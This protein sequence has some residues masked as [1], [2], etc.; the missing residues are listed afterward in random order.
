MNSAYQARIMERFMSPN[1]IRQFNQ[2]YKDN[3]RHP[4]RSSRHVT[5]KDLMIL[6]DYKAGLMPNELVRKY[7]GTN[8]QI[9]TS[10]RIAALSKI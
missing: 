6:K 7:G 8:H 2:E 1:Q 9:N 10:L 4:H 5:D 3:L